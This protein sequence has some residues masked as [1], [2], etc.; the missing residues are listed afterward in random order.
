MPPYLV[1]GDAG[2]PPNDG[3]PDNTECFPQIIQLR[4]AATDSQTIALLGSPM[5]ST[6]KKQRSPTVPECRRTAGSGL[7]A[8]VPTVSQHLSRWV[9]CQR[10][11]ATIVLPGNPVAFSKR[12]EIANFAQ[13]NR[14]WTRS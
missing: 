3:V 6:G 8:A 11:Q 2:D 12:A 9:P 1:F 5:R 13:K 4:P 7:A 14:L 10:A